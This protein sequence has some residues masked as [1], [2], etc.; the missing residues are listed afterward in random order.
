MSEIMKRA[1]G[2]KK[3]S[4]KEKTKKRSSSA[5]KISCDR[6]IPDLM[7]KQ[8]DLCSAS[9]ISLPA[10]GNAFCHTASE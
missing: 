10:R 8:M 9:K 7:L 1:E 2:V 3:T 4:I 6:F 5:L